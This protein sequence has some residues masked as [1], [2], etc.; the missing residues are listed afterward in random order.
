MGKWVVLDFEEVQDHGLRVSL[1][2]GNEGEPVDMRVV[3][4]LPIDPDL[5]TGVDQ[6]QDSY[7]A[8][9]L[10]TRIKPKQIYTGSIQRRFEHCR[11]AA[12]QVSNGLSGWLRSEGFSP[13]NDRLREEL[14]RTDEVRVLIRTKQPSL[15]RLPWHQWDFFDRYRHAEYALSHPNAERMRSRPARST[16]DM[17]QVL[18]IL[19]DST[20]IDVESDRA[21]FERLGAAG[22]A[23]TFLPEPTREE[24]HASLWQQPWDI[25]CFSG[26]SKTQGQTGRLFIN[27]TDSITVEELRYGLQQAIASGLQLAIFNSCDGLGL[28]YDLA[29]LHIP[30][31]ILMRAP[32]PDAVAQVFLRSFLTEYA[33]GR[34]LYLAERAA[35]E[36]L[37]ALEHQFPCASW[38]PVIF[39]NSATTPPTWTDLQRRTGGRMAGQIWDVQPLQSMAKLRERS[40]L[41]W[42]AVRRVVVASIIVTSLVVGVRSLGVLQPAEL[43]AYDRLMQLR[44]AEPPDDRILMI[45]IDEADRQYQQERGWSLQ[46][47]LADEALIELIEKIR[48]HQ[49]AVFGFGLLRD[50][51]DNPDLVHKL[52]SINGWTGICTFSHNVYRSGHQIKV[53]SPFLPNVVINN[54]NIGFS[55]L[56]QEPEKRFIIRRHLISWSEKDDVCQANESFSAVVSRLYLKHHDRSDSADEIKRSKFYLDHDSGGYQL[57]KNH[58]SAR[59]TLLNYRSSDPPM[60]PLEYVLSGSLDASLDELVRDKVVLLGSNSETVKFYTPMSQEQESSIVI[61]AHGISQIISAVLDGRPLIRWWPTWLETIWILTWTVV[62]GLIISI[63]QSPKH[64]MIAVILLQFGIFVVCYALFCL[65]W[66]IPLIPVSLSILLVSLHTVRRPSREISSQ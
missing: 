20:G 12:T 27:Q 5:L 28:A 66:W 22:A 36:Q 46:G 33:Q 57:P 35:R 4:E 9:E 34:S 53:S 19:G 26:H 30:Q 11:V 2:V 7:Y 55:N 37:Q 14:S 47:S 43:H 29:E 40:R 65:G 10:P 62:A 21:E 15:Q 54:M 59:A 17:V 25:L 8:L 41:T 23:V 60:I 6:W 24:L 18:V 63:A 32:V 61:H 38:L 42:A 16:T 50:R 56:I 45:T 3:H 48:P 13:I 1:E 51:V 52:E 44:P 31:M 64:I 49:P 39:Q 58:Q